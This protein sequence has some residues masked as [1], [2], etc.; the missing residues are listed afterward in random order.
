M[1]IDHRASVILLGWV[2][3]L[4]SAALQAEIPELAAPSQLQIDFSQHIEPLFEEQ[5]H[6]CHGEAL[7]LGGLRLD[8]REATLAGGYSGPV[9][10]PGN[11][12]ESRLIH[13]VAGMDEKVAMPLEG[14]RLTPEQV[15]LLRAWIDQG[16]LWA[17][18][19]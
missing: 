17:E 4:G 8:T 15:G 1:S 6:K 13:L 7:Q 18:S 5:C 2:L 9:V 12:A 14:E 10:L 16:A 3:F 11:S 19:K